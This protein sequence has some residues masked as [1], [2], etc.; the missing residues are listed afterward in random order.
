MEKK[1]Y[2]VDGKELRTI[3]LDDNVFGL[4][5]NE[6]VI[7]YAI[8]NELANKRV[9]TACT[10]GRA[11]VHGS[12]AKPYKQKGTGNARRGDKKSPLLVGGGTVFGPKPRDFSYTLPKKMKRL[13]MKSIL[14]QK[15]QD[16]RLMIIEDFTVESGKT[17]DLVTILNRFSKDE[18]TVVVLK[19]DDRLIRRAGRNIPN[20]SFLSYNRLRAHD[21]FYGRKVIMLETAA[22]NLAD[23]YKTEKEAK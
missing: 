20:L 7:Y 13:A 6:D 16:D 12:N 10:K 19:D 3:T 22:K 17:K 9:G 14:S 21:L 18:R 11:E 23:F 2:S 15:A 1:V 8:N 5:V 4:P